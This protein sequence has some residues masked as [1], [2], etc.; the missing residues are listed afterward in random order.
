[1]NTKL[2]AKARGLVEK[3]LEQSKDDAHGPGVKS[4]SYLPYIAMCRETLTEA[5][6]EGMEEAAKVSDDHECGDEDDM[7]C[8]GQ[9]CGPIIAAVIRQMIEAEGES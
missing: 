2:E 7:I 4:F 8:Q 3:I 9:N 5:H 1:M 6:S